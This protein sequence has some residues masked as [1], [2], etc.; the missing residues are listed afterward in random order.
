MIIYEAE[1]SVTHFIHSMGDGNKHNKKLI[2][3][4]THKKRKER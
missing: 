2:I 3:K 4:K 1:F